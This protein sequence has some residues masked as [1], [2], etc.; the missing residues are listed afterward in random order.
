MAYASINIALLIVE[1]P[2][3]SQ[4]SIVD[5]GSAVSKSSSFSRKTRVR[6]KATLHSAF[7]VSMSTNS[8]CHFSLSIPKLC[9]RSFSR[10]PASPNDITV[11]E[12]GLGEFN[13]IFKDC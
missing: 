13:R 10:S 6:P 7:F 8:F 12:G 2:K 9:V 4:Y 11:L 1:N 3:P 5:T